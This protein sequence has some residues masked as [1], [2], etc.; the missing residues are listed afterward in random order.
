MG[1]LKKINELGSSQ[2]IFLFLLISNFLIGP[3][4]LLKLGF[5]YY[6]TYSN[7]GFWTSSVYLIEIGMDFFTVLKDTWFFWGLNI[8]FLLGMFLFNSKEGGWKKP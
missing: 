1:F 5:I 8:V 4:V 3:P 7:L 6:P 2:K